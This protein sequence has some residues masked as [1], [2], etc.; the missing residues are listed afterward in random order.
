[1][2]DMHHENKNPKVFIWDWVAAVPIIP[3][4]IWPSV[5]RFQM[6]AVFLLV[7]GILGLCKV[8]TSA[9]VLKMLAKGK[10]KTFY[11]RSK[12]NR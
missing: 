4:G 8:R 2:S 1:M 9:L 10:G 5:D 7:M 6:Y 11:A 3:L 12:N